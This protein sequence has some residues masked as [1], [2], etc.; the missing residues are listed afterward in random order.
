MDGKDAL[1]DVELAIEQQATDHSY[2][3][4]VCQ[5]TV[6]GAQFQSGIMDY[7]FS[8]GRPSVWFPSKSYFTVDVTLQGRSVAGVAGQ[9]ALWEGLAFSEN[10]VGNMFTNAY[11][12]AGGQSVSNITSYL[13]QASAIEFRTG[14][15]FAYNRSV[16]QQS[17]SAYVGDFTSR[18]VAVSVQDQLAVP[19]AGQAVLP[20]DGQTGVALTYGK[21]ELIRPVAVAYG[22][23]T[24]AIPGVLLGAP[25]LVNGV[26]T[27]FLPQHQGASL[28]VGGTTYKILV[29]AAP[30]GAGCITVDINPQNGVAPTANWYLLQRNFTRSTQA[31]NRVLVQWR[32][33]IGIFSYDKPLG[34]GDYRMSLNPDVNY[35]LSAV[36]SIN[37][38]STGVGGGPAGTASYALTVNDMR[39]Y[40]AIAKMSIPSSISTLYLKEY[41]VQSKTINA[42]QANLSYTVP[43]STE[44]IHVFLQA[45]Q[46]GTSPLLPP[47][48]F[49]GNAQSDLLLQT[50]Q[51]TYS[52]LTKPQ[53]PLKSGSVIHVPP[54]VG[55]NQNWQSL[56]YY[57]SLQEQGRH[58]SEGAETLDE[59][60][61]RGPY[62]SFSFLRDQ[63]DRSTEVQLNITYSAG[64][65]PT[66]FG[67][68]DTGS[69]IFMVAEYTK[70]CEIAVDQGLIVSVK[71][72]NT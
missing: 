1:D 70:T 26:N 41:L 23:A 4:V 5:R 44:C 39:F 16:G 42:T 12:Y 30:N 40:V 10:F 14:N 24:V 22:T 62:Y 34:S 27:N 13:P 32:P 71:S 36:E 61:Q 20:I 9:P 53:T 67:T 18:A 50:I 8:I 55:I 52:G 69:K 66:K 21:E 29:V 65:D 60:L 28:V 49:I 45:P 7:V 54:N 2:I 35:H 31:S 3:E 15:S 43:S 56:L 47:N 72:L 6:A 51:I 63:S 46:S 68:F 25:V 59:Y 17:A 37:P 58:M 38:F 48:R 57:N 19:N 11:F 64:G 33:P